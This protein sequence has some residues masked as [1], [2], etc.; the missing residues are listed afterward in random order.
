MFPTYEGFDL[1]HY[2]RKKS[3]LNAIGPSVYELSVIAFGTGYDGLRAWL[4]GSETLQPKKPANK[5]VAGLSDE[6][7]SPHFCG[8][9]SSQGG[10]EEPCLRGGSGQIRSGP[11]LLHPF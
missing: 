9:S 6:N 2:Q 10:Q 11:S 1:L 4:G 8:G 3:F 7:R 5:K